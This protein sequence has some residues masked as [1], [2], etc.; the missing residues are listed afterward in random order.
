MEVALPSWEKF[1]LLTIKGGIFLILLTPLVFTK[2]FFYPTIAPQT[3]YF[4]V[5]VEFVFAL[6]I[7]LL[8][9]SRGYLPRKS[10]LLIALGAFLA[11][12]AFT[13]FAGIHPSKS[14]WGTFHRLEG[15]IAFIHYGLF[16]IVLTG[17]FKQPKGWISFFRLALVLSMPIAIVGI[18]EYLFVTDFLPDG[19]DW[20][21]LSGTLGNPSLYGSYLVFLMFIG[22]LLAFW[23]QRNMWKITAVAITTFNG[24][25]LLLSGTRGAWLAFIAGGIVLFLLWLLFLGKHSGRRY[26]RALLFGIAVLLGIFFTAVFAWQHHIL[27]SNIFWERYQF[28][29]TELN[30]FENQRFTF[31]PVAIEAWKQSPLFGYGLESFIHL[32]DIYYEPSF[33]KA[34]AQTSFFDRAHNVFLELLTASGIVGLLAY[35]AVF[36]SALKMLWKTYRRN[37]SLTPFVLISLLVA[38][39]AQ[40]MFLFDITA[41]SLLFF[42]VLAFIHVYSTG[43]PSSAQHAFSP[44][45]PLG[46][47]RAVPR[48]YTAIT[49]STTLLL[50]IAANYGIALAHMSL[51]KGQHLLQDLQST[52]A[53]EQFAR[54][55]DYGPPSIRLG[56]CNQSIRQFV[57]D[58]FQRFYSPET[59]QI[60]ETHLKQT[61]RQFEKDLEEYPE[62]AQ[63]LYYTELANAYRNLYLHTENTEY[64]AQEEAVLQK[65]MQINPRF[66]QLTSLLEELQTFQ[67]K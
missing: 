39:L 43:L 35:L 24:V 51:A 40:N 53:F 8:L 64:L 4:R 34:I 32:Y 44:A 36:A 50:A 11:I 22:I 28:A 1:L 55:C 29:W 63:V 6:Y 9:E 7:L 19:V 62:M 41:T 61:A 49:L 65:A 33:L 42:F 14:F 31:W 37:S 27:P 2:A 10:S 57:V 45:S 47:Q 18:L 16:F 25:F 48:A 66:P 58:P 46:S 15:L 5:L 23:E 54:A 21:R 38:Y 26:S 17:V 52:L 30:A 56:A 60:R 67:N 59:K 13:S 3:I 12:L 20:T